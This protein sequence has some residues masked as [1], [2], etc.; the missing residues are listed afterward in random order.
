MLM[1]ARYGRCNSSKLVSWSVSN[2]IAFCCD[3]CHQHSV[4]YIEH[5]LLFQQNASELPQ[6]IQRWGRTFFNRN[7]VSNIATSVHNTEQKSILDYF[8]ILL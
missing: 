3:S 6:F 7:P 8:T 5:L 1:F 2:Y 4:H